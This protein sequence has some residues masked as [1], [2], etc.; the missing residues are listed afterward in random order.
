MQS[1]RLCAVGLDQT[2]ALV[3]IAGRGYRWIDETMICVHVAENHRHEIPEPP[4]LA[5]RPARVAATGLR[6]Q[7]G[8]P[9]QPFGRVEIRGIEPLTS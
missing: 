3:G 1:V 2:H 6:K 4:P 8:L 7:K 9:K 5:G